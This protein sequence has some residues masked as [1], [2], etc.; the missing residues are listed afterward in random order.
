M[1]ALGAIFP[2]LGAS[3]L[4][5]GVTAGLQPSSE[6]RPIRPGEILKAALAIQALSEAGKVPVASTDPF[7]GNLVVSTADQEGVLLGILSERADRLDF[8][9]TQE[10]EGALFAA[11]ERFIDRAAAAS[12]PTSALTQVSAPAFSNRVTARPAAGGGVERGGIPSSSAA[13]PSAISRL[14]TP[15]AGPQTGISR[16]RC[17]G[18]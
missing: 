1:V 15:C 17:G 7:T 9:F 4:G 14:S 10:D 6:S 2:V 16:L 5:E 12:R 13:A 8:P 11:R 3:A 18:V